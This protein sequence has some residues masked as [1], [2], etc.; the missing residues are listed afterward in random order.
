MKFFT[1]CERSF[2]FLRLLNYQNQYHAS[3]Q[4]N[5]FKE[6]KWAEV[7]LIPFI[8]H[9]PLK[10]QHNCQITWVFNS[11]IHPWFEIM[12][13][14]MG[15]NPFSAT[16]TKWS[17]KLK[18]FVGNLPTNCLSVSDHFVGLALKG[19]SKNVTKNKYTNHFSM[20]FMLGKIF[21]VKFH[22]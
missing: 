12:Y 16:F 21:L 6:F 8:S 5:K 2:A 20:K 4:A 22:L 13:S 10:H 1:F 7:L 9:C 14:V 17:N 18:Q 15:I 11:P 19:L 3:F